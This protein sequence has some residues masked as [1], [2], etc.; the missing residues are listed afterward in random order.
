MKTLEIKI[1]GLAE[2]DKEFVEVFKAV[3]SGKKVAPRKGVYF[4]S[5]EAVR[6]LLTKKRLELLHLIRE[7]HPKSI[8]ELAKVAG[9]NFK[10]VYDDL[11]ILKDY[12]LV[13][14]NKAKHVKR[15]HPQSITVPYQ[16][17]NIHAA[18]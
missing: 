17:I 1:K 12:G 15:T 10:N 3:Q 16:M 9:R 5:L 13:R 4:T 8:Y 7:N 18:I 6:N 14:M 2:A 11:Q